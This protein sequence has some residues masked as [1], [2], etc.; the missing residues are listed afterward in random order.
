[1]NPGY[2]GRTELPD[3]LK[4]L[5]RPVAMMTPDLA[6]IAEV[7]L[8]SE[9]FREA[10][11]LAKKTITLYTLMTQQLSKQDHYDYGLRNLKAVLNMAGTLKRAEP[12]LNEEVI[13]MRALR[14]M[15]LPKFIKDD[16]RLF[17]LLLSDLFPGIELPVSIY[18][19]LDMAFRRELLRKG[20]QEH[21]FLLYKIVQLYDSK[22]TRHCNMLVGSS[23]AG[24]SVAWNTLANAKTSLCKEDGVE[25]FYPVHPHIINAKAINLAELYGEYDL[26]T[27]EWCDGILSKLF[28]GCAESEKPDEKWIVFDGPSE[29]IK[30]SLLLVG[31]FFFFR[32][33]TTATF[34]VVRD[35][36]TF[37]VGILAPP[38]PP[39]LSR[40]F[41]CLV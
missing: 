14:D 17:R 11:D 8:A 10:K 23:N 30:K 16:E 31:F 1:M 38:P 6:L 18:E 25:G 4:A 26:A 3:N 21:E 5:M 33:F 7:M 41:P 27:F 34:F 19:T 13:M 22:L 29:S 20:L 9:G 2:A 37:L 32:V 12:T 35:A 15:N 40:L 39:S 36:K 24:K 28:K